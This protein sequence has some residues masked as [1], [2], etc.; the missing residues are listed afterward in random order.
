MTETRVH[1]MHCAFALFADKGYESTSMNDLVRKSGLSKGAFYHYFHNK[2]TLY[3]QTL[4]HYFL[5]FFATEPAPST[6]LRDYTQQ[7]W[8]GYAEMLRQLREV[9][10][11]LTAYYRLFLAAVP[12]SDGA[13]Q[14]HY[15]Q[16]RAELTRLAKLHLRQRK[17]GPSIKPQAVADHILGLIEGTGLLLVMNPTE[18]VEGRLEAALESYLSLL[19]G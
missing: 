13:I 5:R 8:R 15:Q 7:L 10:P 4:H 19:E 11:D 18:D 14:R 12:L 6:T 1:I 17:S 3:Q 16:A 9:S 2:Q